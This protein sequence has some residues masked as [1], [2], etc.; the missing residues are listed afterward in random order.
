MTANAG[1]I[2]ILV[3]GEETEPLGDVGAVASGIILDADHLKGG[4]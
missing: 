3:N 2:E 4:D 1:G